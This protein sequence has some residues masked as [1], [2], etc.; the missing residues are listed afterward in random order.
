VLEHVGDAADADVLVLGSHVVEDLHRR[1][2]RLVIGQ[3]QHLEAVRQLPRHD[4]D[5]G[6]H[7]LGRNLGIRGGG[8]RGHGTEREHDRQREPPA[9]ATAEQTTDSQHGGGQL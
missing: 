1:D 3:E 5:L 6:H 4:L 8:D 7:E 9:V 2:R